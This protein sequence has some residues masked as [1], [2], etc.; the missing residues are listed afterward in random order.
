M[1]TGVFSDVHSNMEGLEAVLGALEAAGANQYV[2]LGDLVGYGAEPNEVIDRIRD[3]GCPVIMGNHDWAVSD[4]KE[5]NVFNPY[6]KTAIEWT[7][8]KLSKENQSFLK[9]LPLQHEDGDILYVH[10]SPFEPKLWHYV[11]NSSEYKSA[12]S[13][14]C[15]F[16]ACFIGHTHR[17]MIAVQDGKGHIYPHASRSVRLLD[18]FRYLINDGSTGQSRDGLTEA[19]CALYDDNEQTVELIR[20]GYNVIATRAKIRDAGLPS[21]LEERLGKGI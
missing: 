20:V 21:F 6:A 2:C 14:M 15:D 8:S 3:L 17:P 16:K 5:R 13:A 1:K 11:D 7:A 12:F 19:A 9:N 18:G 10:A 4:K